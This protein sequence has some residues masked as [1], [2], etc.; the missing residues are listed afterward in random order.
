MWLAPNVL[1]FLGMI[2]VLAAFFLVSYFDYYLLAS[3]DDFPQFPPIPNWVWLVCSVFTFVAH[4]AGKILCSFSSSSIHCASFLDGTDGKQA[5]RTGASG[6]TGELF[7]HGIDSY[8][9]VAFTVTAFSAVGRFDY[10]YGLS[11][12]PFADETA[13]NNAF[14][15]A[16]PIPRNS[17]G[18]KIMWEERCVFMHQKEIGQKSSCMIQFCNRI[19]E[20]R[21]LTGLIM[22][23]LNQFCV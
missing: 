13:L 17:S 1:T 20:I 3:S 15:L 21:F 4:V 5:R 8:M 9:T 6:P 16:N 18:F 19:V 10:R 23:N 12:S 22:K 2:L 7:D 11:L 14:P